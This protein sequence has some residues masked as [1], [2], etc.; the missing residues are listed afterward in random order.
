MLIGEQELISELGVGAVSLDGVRCTRMGEELVEGCR[1]V[2]L[3]DPPR[4]SENRFGVFS[5]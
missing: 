1:D 2:A 3:D 4:L 5:F